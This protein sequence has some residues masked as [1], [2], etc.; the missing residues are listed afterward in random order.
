VDLT[1][2]NFV[3]DGFPLGQ[4]TYQIIGAAMTV[5]RELGHGFL[6]AVY[7]EALALE[8]TNRQIPFK[9]EQP[10]SIQYKGQVLNKRY[11]ADFLCFDQVIIELK[12]CD[13]IHDQHLAQ[14]LNYLKATNQKLG[15]LLN[16][17]S[18]SLQYKRVIL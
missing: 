18:S 4:E 8:F 7:Q 9:K 5:H 14:V 3:N 13:G 6:E 17:G 2:T 16:F 10:L 15:L 11:Y 1:L 12:A